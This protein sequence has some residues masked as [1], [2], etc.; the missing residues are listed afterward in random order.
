VSQD[1]PSDELIN[2]TYYV[3]AIIDV[4]GQS[5]KLQSLTAIPQ[6]PQQKE[7]FTKVIRDTFGA[8]G[9]L[10]K[11]F[12]E[13]FEGY[14]DPCR[15]HDPGSG[16]L[17]AGTKEA[18]IEP[19]KPDLGEVYFSDMFLFYA[20]VY[21]QDGQV[22]VN[23]IYSMLTA[24]ATLMRIALAGK[25]AIR[26]GIDIGIAAEFGPGD[27]YGRALCQANYL[28][29]HV[30]QYPR[31][32]IGPELMQFIEDQA[33]RA[34]TDDLSKANC[35]MARTCKLLVQ[36]DFDGIPFVDFLGPAM[37]A[38]AGDSK[39]KYQ[40]AI[41]AGHSFVVGEHER[42]KKSALLSEHDRKLAQRYGVLRAYYEGRM[43]LWNNA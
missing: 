30:A 23:A 12:R 3:V 43:W 5:E 19:G 9:A 36:S 4:L 40:Q 22:S 7:Q 13:F 11:G 18:V 15:R 34:A 28:E 14:H 6:T 26:G 2:Y 33:G 24:S 25:I 32:V 39:P 8:V 31:I 17:P 1:R 35:I 41:R 27:P 16:S 10:R 37:L 29:R 20:P 21:Q 38:I 42:F